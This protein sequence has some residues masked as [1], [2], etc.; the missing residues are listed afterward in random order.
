[1]KK[2][3]ME[4]FTN[5]ND[6]TNKAIYATYFVDNTPELYVLN[7]DRKIIGKNLKVFQIDTVIERD[8]EER[9]M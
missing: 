7:P 8:K 9:G 2:Y 3:G 5:V 6:P 4:G 1:M